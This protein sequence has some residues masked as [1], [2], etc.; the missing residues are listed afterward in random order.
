MRRQEAG[1]KVTRWLLIAM[2][3]LGLANLAGVVVL[4]LRS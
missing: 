1:A 4:L 3:I 2:L